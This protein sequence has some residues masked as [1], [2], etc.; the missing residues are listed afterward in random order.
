M[1]IKCLQLK[2][3]YKG[4]IVS[5]CYHG[6][7]LIIWIKKNKKY[8]YEGYFYVNQIHGYGR[9]TYGNGLIFEVTNKV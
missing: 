3:I 4:P 7:G 2:Q 5:G 6:K 1:N 9:M 8:T